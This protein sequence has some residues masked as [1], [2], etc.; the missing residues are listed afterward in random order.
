[1]IRIAVALSLLLVF[2][3]GVLGQE[4]A[5]ND[6]REWATPGEQNGWF[7]PTTPAQLGEYLADLAETFEAVALDTL[8]WVNGGAAEPDSA[9][10]VLLA[11]VRTRTSGER[12]RVRVLVL[13]GQRGDGLSGTEVALQFV[14]ELALGDIRSLLDDLEV[15]LVPAANPWGLLWWIPE[16]PSGVYLTRDHTLLQSPATKA[17][18]DLVAR[19]RPHL[20][21]E[22]REMGPTVYRVQAGLPRHPNIDPALTSY[23]RF[24]LLPYVANELAR[25]SVTFRELVVVEP[26]ADGLGTPLL[27]ADDLPEG[28]YLTPGYIGADGASNSFSL[29]GSLSILLGVSSLGGVDGLADRVQLLYQALGYLLEVSTAQ[30]DGLRVPPGPVP[31]ALS[32][33]QAYMR[34]E[35]RPNLVWLVWNDRGQIVQ[36]TTDRWRPL[37]RRQLA[38]PVPA[39]WVIEPRGREWAALIASHGFTVERLRRGATLQLGSYGVG[40]TRDLPAG[41]ADDLPLDSAPDGS[42]LLLWEE[43]D[44]PEGAWL[45]RADQ[46]RTRLLFTLIEP[47]SQDAPLGRET[48]TGE[49]G[50]ALGQYPVHRVA[51]GTSLRS[52]RTEPAKLDTARADPGD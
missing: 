51:A 2:P 27:G 11:A 6:L 38:L 42:N 14:R 23:G 1:M 48:V 4:P 37:V 17:V 12:D 31:P 30:A 46:P 34:D 49:H 47:W 41:L 44:I 28:G 9:L 10:P 50:A 3:S 33:R 19:W 24:Y 36:Q 29:G 45:V 35:E 8:A 25:A 52:L 18:H 26:E 7:A 22:L 40:V 13:A 16:E 32:L 39:A 5:G 15:A 21:V 43:R 20:V